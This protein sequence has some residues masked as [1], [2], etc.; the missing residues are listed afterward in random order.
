[1][2]PLGGGGER[3]VVGRGSH[4]SPRIVD[5]GRH[6]S[7]DAETRALFSA[8]DKD[9]NGYIDKN[10]LRLTMLEVGLDLSARD[11]DTMMR[12]AGVVIKDRIFYEGL[13][14]FSLFI[15]MTGLFVDCKFAVD[16]YS[17]VS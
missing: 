2:D 15:V 5:R 3:V 8:L 4:G 9:R 13:N 17:G 12:A 11:L 16:V 14:Y 1:M 10:E 6:Q 7:Q